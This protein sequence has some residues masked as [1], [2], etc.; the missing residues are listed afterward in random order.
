MNIKFVISE[1]LEFVFLTIEVIITALVG[2]AIFITAKSTNSTTLIDIIG[3][4]I[5]F[6]LT[7][8]FLFLIIRIIKNYVFNKLTERN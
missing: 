4:P 7:S 2:L 6:V 5:Y 8:L 1:I 3:R